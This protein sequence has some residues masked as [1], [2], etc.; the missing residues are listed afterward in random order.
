[1]PAP[2]TDDRAARSERLL[3]SILEGAPDISLLAPGFVYEQHFGNTEGTY[4]GEE[5]SSAGSRPSTRCGI[6]RI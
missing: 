5:A 2:Q 3:Q 4:R 6:A 1:M